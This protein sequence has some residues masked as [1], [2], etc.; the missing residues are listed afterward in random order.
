MITDNS[1]ISKSEALPIGMSQME[2]AKEDLL[3]KTIHPNE[4]H[5]STDHLLDNLKH[6]T[7]SSGFVTIIAQGVLF[8]LGLASIMVTG[9]AAHA[10]GFRVVRHGNNYNGLRDDL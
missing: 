6:R 9:T 1:S 4:K 8:V 5:L 2:T 10:Q 3:D 7:I